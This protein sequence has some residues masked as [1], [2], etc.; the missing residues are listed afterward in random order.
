MGKM[1]KMTMMVAF[2]AVVVAIF[3]TAAYAAATTVYG[4]N[5]DDFV[6]NESSGFEDDRIYA[7]AGDDYINAA[8]V[9]ST[10][11]IESDKLFGGRGDDTLGADDGNG[12]DFLNGGPGYDECYGT[13]GDRFANCEL[14]SREPLE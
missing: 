1:R 12:T 2:S 6:I 5:G 7:L 3:T 8:V 14:I 10:T 13:P 9:W 4:T 11:I